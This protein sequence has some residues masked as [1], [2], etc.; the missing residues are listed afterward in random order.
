MRQEDLNDLTESVIVN[1]RLSWIAE[2]P[3]KQPTISISMDYTWV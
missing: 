2:F 3:H 1:Q